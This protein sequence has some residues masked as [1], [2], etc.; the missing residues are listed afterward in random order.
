[1][2]SVRAVLSAA[3][4]V[5]L[6]ALAVAEPSKRMQ[7]IVDAVNSQPGRT[8]TAVHPKDRFTAEVQLARASRLNLHEPLPV[9]RT[10]VGQAQDGRG[11]S[12]A[13]AARQEGGWS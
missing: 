9:A 10:R 1:M 11:A 12:H 5:A 7:E 6:C 13:P 2:A 4:L 8:W 3:L